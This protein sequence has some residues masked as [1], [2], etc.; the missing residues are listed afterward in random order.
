MNNNSFSD[1]Y[2]KAKEQMEKR[3]SFAS[4]IANR[5]L[6]KSQKIRAA[7]EFLKQGRETPE[8]KF[9]G[10]QTRSGGIDPYAVADNNIVNRLKG[11]PSA[12]LSQMFTGDPNK[13]DPIL[14]TGGT[15]LDRFKNRPLAGTGRPYDEQR[16]TVTWGQSKGKVFSPRGSEYYNSNPGPLE[17]IETLGDLGVAPMDFIYRVGD[18][19]TQKGYKKGSTFLGRVGYIFSEA[20]KQTKEA[21][22]TPETEE[23][24]YAH[25][26]GDLIFQHIYPKLGLNTDEWTWGILA[27]KDEQFKQQP[28]L[29]T[30]RFLLN[31]F[32]LYDVGGLVGLDL[33]KS[34]YTKNMDIKEWAELGQKALRK[35]AKQ[36]DKQSLQIF[37]KAIK[38]L[39][40]MMKD[41]TGS[42]RIPGGDDTIDKAK[43]IAK[44]Q[45]E[46][47]GA[48][49][50]K[51]TPYDE[52]DVSKMASQA[53]DKM[54]LTGEFKTSGTAKQARKMILEHFDTVVNKY[55]LKVKD[56]ADAIESILKRFGSAL[57]YETMDMKT[58]DKVFETLV[59]EDADFAQRVLAFIKNPKAVPTQYWEIAAMK[60]Y[61]RNIAPKSLSGDELI[62][63]FKMFKQK[64]SKFGGMLKMFDNLSDTMSPRLAGELVQEAG[65]KAGKSS[66]EILQEKERVIKEMSEIED[67]FKNLKP[68]ADIET[69]PD[70]L[71]QPDTP[72]GRRAGRKKAI[73]TIDKIDNIK[74]KIDELSLPD[75]KL[76]PEIIEKQQRYRELLRQQK[77]IE[78]YGNKIDEMTDD[79]VVSII[80]RYKEIKKMKSMKAYVERYGEELADLTDE[81]LAALIGRYNQIRKQKGIQKYI[82]KYGEQFAEMTDEELKD[83]INQYKRLKKFKSTQDFVNKWG[84]KLDEMTPEELADLNK[85]ADEIKEIKKLERQIENF[86]KQKN[87]EDIKKL[88]KELTAEKEALDAKKQLEEYIKQTG[89]KMTPYQ[90]KQFM[91][92][93][94][95]VQQEYLAG[96]TGEYEALQTL[97]KELYP[98]DVSDRAAA[99]LATRTV[100]ELKWIAKQLVLDKHLENIGLDV[101]TKAGKTTSLHQAFSHLM[102]TK[103]IFNNL[104]SNYAMAK[105][106]RWNNLFAGT[107]DKAMQYLGVQKIGGHT[108]YEIRTMGIEDLRKLADKLKIKKSALDG[109]SVKQVKDKIIDSQLSVNYKNRIDKTEL[110]A[111]KQNAKNKAIVENF[112]GVS[113]ADNT[114]YNLGS[115]GLKRGREGL[116]G[117]KKRTINERARQA[118]GSVL[119]VP[120]ETAKARIRYYAEQEIKHLR[121]MYDI[122]DIEIDNLIQQEALWATFQDD[123][124]LAHLATKLKDTLNVIGIGKTEKK[125]GSFAVKEFGLGDFV[126]KYPGVA[127]NIIGRTVEYSPVGMLKALYNFSE[128]SK[129][130]KAGQVGA[131]F[132]LQKRKAYVALS[133]AM[134]G[135]GLMCLGAYM[136]N[137]GLIKV[138]GKSEKIGDK[139]LLSA[140]GLKDINLNLSATMRG[141]LGQG[142][143]W[144]EDDVVIGLNWIEPFGKIIQ[145]GSILAETQGFGGDEKLTSTARNTLEELV[146][147][148]MLSIVQQIMYRTMSHDDDNFFW[149]FTIPV[150]SGISGFVPATVRNIAGAT[151]IY[152][153]DYST[154]STGLQQII[155]QTRSSLMG[156]V[157][158]ARQKLPIKTEVT[159]EQL[160]KNPVSQIINSIIRVNS[161]VY[162]PTG[163]T[164]TL[165]AFIKRATEL[166]VDDP[167]SVLPTSKFNTFKL[168]TKEYELDGEQRNKFM[169][170][171]G[172]A[173]ADA[174][175]SFNLINYTEEEIAQ[176]DKQTIKMWQSALRRTESFALQK[177]KFEVFMEYFYKGEK[178]TNTTGQTEGERET[179]RPSSSGT[180]STATIGGNNEP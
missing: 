56:K 179:V 166:E 52:K 18:V 124:F 100:D 148:P 82:D 60:K 126:I 90:K 9:Q 140:E 84:K 86:K 156:A 30:T 20:Y 51:N 72:H 38:Q 117:L 66:D 153:R 109:L 1:S 134:S 108:I 42:V 110:K 10:S 168:N 162:K 175:K 63:T 40:E 120:D 79:Q 121:E 25:G 132:V 129:L 144:Q 130:K 93:F 119:K 131:D 135:T 69:L 78:K 6:T 75:S 107:L 7:L 44:E 49:V 125:I 58:M 64:A 118:L 26:L 17:I 28:V 149:S 133:R 173:Y 91:E 24:G 174:I 68:K 47:L 43:K 73:E 11:R 80:N 158:G 165:T 67:T 139:Q 161:S 154:S 87:A 150:A 116:G 94:K 39:K 104:M 152:S 177:A 106:Y 88:K 128:L 115:T 157:P 111:I 13:Q 98:G 96:G 113:T 89:R 97:I 50:A 21:I 141:I 85:K 27:P 138:A 53:I 57:D 48:P 92:E 103:T 19:D 65:E 137:Q 146:D 167:K 169:E 59:E 71:R 147:L 77:F 33:L 127:M 14:K 101:F 70:D 15:Y 41:E 36:N 151:D 76:E 45:L 114:K 176:M 16:A 99:A 23:G 61:I 171:Y 3:P 8:E 74:G 143:E 105:E 22:E 32:D 12:V 123:S 55:G 112:F 46:K 172:R 29:E 136:K 142:V 145:I 95:K 34:K 159:G 54:F 37:N 164:E 163:F 122:S 178:K 2:L 4:L 81:E 31:M 5:T 155:D 62:E 160:K 83:L 102:S 35:L 170:V 180:R